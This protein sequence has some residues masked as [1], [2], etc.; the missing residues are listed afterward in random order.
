MSGKDEHFG[1]LNVLGCRGCIEC[2]VGNKKS[3]SIENQ[4]FMVS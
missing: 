4:G 1:Y 3:K 2:H